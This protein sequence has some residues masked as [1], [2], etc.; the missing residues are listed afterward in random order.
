MQMN[1]S[2]MAAV[3]VAAA[4]SAC[5]IEP[6]V[7]TSSDTDEVT[8]AALRSAQSAAGDDLKYLYDVQCRPW[9]PALDAGI[10]SPMK[11]TDNLYYV[12]AGTVGAWALDTPDGIVVL[13]AMN[14]AAEAKTLVAGGL[15]A[16]GLDPARIRYV[17]VHHGHYDHMGGAA[18]LQ[19]TYGAKVWMTAGDYEMAGKD[20]I[21]RK[22]GLQMPALDYAIADGEVLRLGSTTLTF[23]YTPG[24][25]PGTI[26]TILTT[27]YRGEPLALAIWGGT[28]FPRNPQALDD[29]VRSVRSF[30]AKARAA[31]VQGVLSNH[32]EVDDVMARMQTL[33]RNPDVNPFI[34][35]ENGV[36]R[37]FAVLEGCATASKSW[38]GTR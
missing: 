2:S 36:Q 20:E 3:V 9:R 17:I 32:G 25:T 10:P 8:A 1:R 30:S 27:S 33:R 14:N 24:H 38:S 31:K 37:F 34:L 26:S 21:N 12:G 16:L 18:F 35:G 11:V 13:D 5:A 6:A 4:L 15:S 29:Y 7:A 28:A 23:H 19:T 22:N